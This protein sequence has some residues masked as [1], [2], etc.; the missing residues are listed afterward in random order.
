MRMRHKLSV[1]GPL[2]FK[3][4]QFSFTL[5]SWP[6][7]GQDTALFEPPCCSIHSSHHLYSSPGGKEGGNGPLVAGNI[8]FLY[9]L[10]FTW[11]HAIGLLRGSSGYK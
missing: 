11:T 10:S 4:N 1:L 7:D 8:H 5:E 2:R 6:G 3:G 9:F